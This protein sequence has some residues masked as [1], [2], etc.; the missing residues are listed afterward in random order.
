MLENIHRSQKREILH[1]CEFLRHRWQGK[2]SSA[3]SVWLILN[4]AFCFFN[5]RIGIFILFMIF[6]KFINSQWIVSGSEDNMVYIWNLQTK[7]IVQKLQGHTG[8]EKT[9]ARTVT[10]ELYKT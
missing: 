4:V 3:F 10:L 5:L 2:A 9:T 6:V 8:K 7:E 1:I